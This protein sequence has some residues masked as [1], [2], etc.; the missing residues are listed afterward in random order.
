MENI[1]MSDERK[2]TPVINTINNSKKISLQDA[3]HYGEQTVYYC[4]CANLV[5]AFQM[6]NTITNAVLTQ[7]TTRRDTM[8]HGGGDGKA[9]KA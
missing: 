3:T 4:H 5:L 9:V 7:R 2:K 1:H 6:A 8:V